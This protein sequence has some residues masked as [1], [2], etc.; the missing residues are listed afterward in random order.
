MAQ[1]ITEKILAR[2]SGRTEVHPGEIVDTVI[3]LA[4]TQDITGAMAFPVFRE[5]GVPVWDRKKIVVFIDHCAPPSTLLHT[6]YVA[7]NIKFVEDYDIVHFYKMQGICHQILP[8]EGFVKPGMAIV[9]TDSH[10]TT[11]GAWGP[12][13]QVSDLLKWSGSSQRDDSGCGCRKP[14]ALR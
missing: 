14:F 7:E 5:L 9:G 8:E 10:T 13:R 6:E 4:M 2:A 1:T 12:S 11:Y 3:D